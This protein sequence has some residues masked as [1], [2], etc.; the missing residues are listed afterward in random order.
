MKAQSKTIARRNFLTIILA[1]AGAAWLAGSVPLARAEE[2]MKMPSPAAPHDGQV[3]GDASLA[4]QAGGK[5]AGVA[6]KYTCPMH[7]EV[8]SAQPGRCPKCGM[9]LEESKP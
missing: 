2:P 5:G 1:V 7:P 6:T 4:G 8:V 3:A 9:Y